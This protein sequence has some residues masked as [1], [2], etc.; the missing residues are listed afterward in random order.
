VQNVTGQLGLKFGKVAQP[1]R[2]AITGGAASPSID[3]TLALL[4]REKTLQRIQQALV[5][6]TEQSANDAD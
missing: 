1:L 2:F 6:I 3:V 5:F 4:G